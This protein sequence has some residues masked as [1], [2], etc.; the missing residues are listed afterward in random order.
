MRTTLVCALAAALPLIASDWSPRAAADYLDARQKAWLEWPTAKAP[1]GVCIS[2]H[3][4][5]TYL[6][7]RP[8]LRAVLHEPDP[9]PYETALLASLRERVPKREGK[10]LFPNFAKETIAAQGAGVES[11]LAALFL[12]SDAAFDRLWSL[13]NKNA[14]PWFQVDLDPWETTDSPFFG[15]ALAAYAIRTGPAQYRDRLPAL[16]A[17]LESAQAA[18]PLHNRLML[19]PATG[20]APKKLIDEIL[21]LQQPDGGWTRESLG[22]WKPRPDAIPSTGSDAYATAFTAWCL[23]QSGT[24][25]ATALTWLRSHQDP[26]HGSWPSAS[27]NKRYPAGGMQDQFMT[28]AATAFAALVLSGHT[29][30][31]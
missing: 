13:Q 4:N 19:I 6:L 18:Q 12:K 27:M 16:T 5:M 25:N 17:Y 21:A 8:A 11:I 31:R 14:W 24:T 20:A 2:C 10:Q 28:D 15:A 26:E 30:P 29:P 22:P 3:T 9:T 23:E 7:A 1:G